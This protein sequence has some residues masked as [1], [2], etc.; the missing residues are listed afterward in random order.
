M[1]PLPPTRFST[2]TGWPSASESFGAKMRPTR[3]GPPPGGNGTRRRIGCVGYCASA[4]QAKTASTS[5]KTLA[6]TESVPGLADSVEV[7]LPHLKIPLA[8][9]HDRLLHVQLLREAFHR[10]PARVR[11][12]DVGLLV[13]SEELQL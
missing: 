4:S 13:Q 2:T 10:A 5:A 3:S 12:R 6:I 1:L 8:R 9:R 11:V 7:H